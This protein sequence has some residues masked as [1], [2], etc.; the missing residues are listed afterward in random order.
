MS[1]PHNIDPVQSSSIVEMELNPLKLKEQVRNLDRCFR[2][3]MQKET[4]YGTIPGT[5]KPTLYKP[6]AEL[7]C[8][9]F[10]LRPETEI[11]AK[12]EDLEAPYFD[13]T[14]KVSLWSRKYGFKVGDG[15]GSANTME[16]RYTFR[17]MWSNEVPADFN[18]EGAVKRTVKTGS[19][20]YRRDAAPD[21]IFTLKNTVLKMAEKRA[22]VDA[23]LR[24]TGASRIFTQDVEDTAVDVEVEEEEKPVVKIPNMPPTKPAVSSTQSSSKP[25]TPHPETVIPAVVKRLLEHQIQFFLDGTR[26]DLPVNKSNEGRIKFLREMF[27]AKQ[28]EYGIA[29]R[30]VVDAAGNIRWL[31]TDDI[32]EKIFEELERNITWALTGSLNV[33]AQK[34]SVR[35]VK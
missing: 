32:P 19:V 30:E 27:A 16:S 26:V 29:I 8:L 23:V 3:L 22:L 14:V 18:K 21:E 11:I 31:E 24:C 25:V 7:L 33:D 13:Y 5:P 9:S 28:K 10:N 1:E 4:D 6:G 34:I 2:E 15:V 12:V 35:A 20:Q 17:W